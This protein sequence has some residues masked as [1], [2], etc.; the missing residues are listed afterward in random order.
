MQLPIEVVFDYMYQTAQKMDLFL[1]KTYNIG[2]H[3]WFRNIT[4]KIHF[5]SMFFYEINFFEVT[6][7]GKSLKSFVCITG[8]VL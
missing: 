5:K 6:V 7:E 3:I 1:A 2:A 4:D 8:R